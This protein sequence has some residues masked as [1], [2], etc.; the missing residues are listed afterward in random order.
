MEV[1]I[2]GLMPHEL[3][4]MYWRENLVIEEDAEVYDAEYLEV[5]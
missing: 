4:M 3:R 1:T 5:A 2:A